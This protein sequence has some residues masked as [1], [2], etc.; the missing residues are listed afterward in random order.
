MP[1]GTREWLEG[2]TLGINEFQTGLK[3]PGEACGAW[4]TCLATTIRRAVNEKR[5]AREELPFH[6]LVDVLSG[7]VSKSIERVDPTL[8]GQT[9]GTTSPMGFP[10]PFLATSR[11]ELSSEGPA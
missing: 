10:F 6:D 11:V 4:L 1:R 3:S 7:L 2:L 9:T 8:V 5:L